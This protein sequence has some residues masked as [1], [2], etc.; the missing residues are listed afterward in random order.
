MLKSKRQKRN[1]NPFCSRKRKKLIINKSKEI[2]NQAKV[3]LAESDKGSYYNQECQWPN[4]CPSTS[5]SSCSVDKRSAS[6][7]KIEDVLVRD[8]SLEFDIDDL[9]LTAS[10]SEDEVDDDVQ[11]QIRG[12]DGVFQKPVCK[13]CHSSLQVVEKTGSKQGL[14]AKWMF[15]CTNEKCISH[16]YQKSLP[17]SPKSG[18]DG[19]MY[20]INRA[21]VIGFRAIGKGRSAAEKCLSFLDLTTPV[22][23]WYK[24]TKII[25]LKAQDLTEQ[26]CSDAMLELKKF[27]RQIGEVGDCTDQELKNKTVDVGAS[28]YCAWSSRGWSARD[29]VVAAIS[30]DTGRVL[31]VVY[32]T[33]SCSHCKKMEE[34]RA[35]RQLSK[36]AFLEWYIGHEEN[37]YLNHEGSAQV[38][39][40]YTLI[41]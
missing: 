28:F 26:N 23:I 22:F 11:E 24:H 29:G 36:I 1:S 39:Q 35:S 12:V 31:D 8:E 40:S 27:K 6:K 9:D 3:S 33:R 21:S 30:E 15:R 37:C 18:K 41:I 19:K 14:G 10:D 38:L 5:S 16:Q 17:T 2:I 32:M 7:R 13:E 20:A 4:E 25:D 34:K